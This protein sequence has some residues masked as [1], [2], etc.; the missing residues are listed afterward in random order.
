MHEKASKKLSVLASSSNYTRFE[1][2]DNIT[3]C[4]DT[5]W[6]IHVDMNVP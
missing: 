4:Q 1:K 2:K 5:I 6:I 3:I